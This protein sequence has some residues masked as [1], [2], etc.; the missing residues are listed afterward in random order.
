MPP[1]N[2]PSSPITIPG[3]GLT[4]TPLPQPEPVVPQRRSLS[5]F[6]L[7]D[8]VTVFSVIGQNCDPDNHT[9]T[10]VRSLNDG[11]HGNK[12]LSTHGTIYSDSGDKHW[13][14]R[15]EVERV[16]GKCQLKITNSDPTPQRFTDLPYGTVFTVKEL[17]SVTFIKGTFSDECMWYYP[18]QTY[19]MGIRPITDLAKNGYQ[20]GFFYNHNN[21]RVCIEDPVCIPIGTIRTSGASYY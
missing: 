4:Y 10:V 21:D 9:Y 7:N 13:Y 1:A 5:E 17:S 18:R 15:S 20:I 6:N 16:D 14:L 11:R 3:L 19:G 2:S 12:P 8:K